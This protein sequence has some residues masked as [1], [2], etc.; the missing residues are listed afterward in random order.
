MKI[1]HGCI[2]ERYYDD[3]EDALGSTTSF[4]FLESNFFYFVHSIYSTQF[5]VLLS[6]F[7]ASY[8]ITIIWQKFWLAVASWTFTREKQGWD[9]E[10]SLAISLSCMCHLDGK[11]WSELWTSFSSIASSHQPLLYTPSATEKHWTT[12]KKWSE[13]NKIMLCFPTPSLLT[14]LVKKWSLLNKK[15]L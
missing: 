4:P 11:K 7:N 1:L 10:I 12:S 3:D 5:P 15:G 13:I 6:L 9:E 2:S 14:T 8:A